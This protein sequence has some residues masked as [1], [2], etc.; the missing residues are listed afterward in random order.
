MI[1]ALPGGLA[2]LLLREGPVQGLDPHVQWIVA[3]A[4][5]PTLLR[6]IQFGDPTTGKP[7]L[8]LRE[9]FDRLRVPLD[10]KLDIASAMADTLDD[11]GSFA[12]S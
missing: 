4:F 6:Q 1:D 2:A 3:G 8:D 5:A 7:S 10:T 11:A 9:L 12:V